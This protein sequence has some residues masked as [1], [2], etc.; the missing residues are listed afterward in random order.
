MRIY[1]VTNA[2]VTRSSGNQVTVDHGD[3]TSTTVD[4]RKN[5]NAIQRSDDGK[6][7]IQTRQQNSKMGNNSNQ[8]DK[9]RP[10]E[11]IEVDEVSCSSSMK[12]KKRK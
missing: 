3:G 1:E 4:T 6:L 8:P 12:K 11:E 2:R 7:K 9:P 10:G 5:P